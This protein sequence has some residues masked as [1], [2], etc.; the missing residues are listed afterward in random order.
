VTKSDDNEKFVRA[1][2]ALRGLRV[3][4]WAGVNTFDSLHA[5][6]VVTPSSLAS[7]TSGQITERVALEILSHEAIIREAYKDSVG[8]WT[9]SA[10]ITSAS[11]HS[12][13]RYKDNPQTLEKCLEVYIWLLREKYAPAVVGAF[14]GHKLTE[15]EF[16][17]ALSFHWNTGAIGRASWVASWK[18]GKIAQ[19]RSQFMEWRKP[20]EIIKRR[21]AECNLFFDGTWSGDGKVTEYQVAKP[22]YAPK[23]SSAKRVDVRADFKA[24]LAS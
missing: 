10:G 22:S 17:A 23:W 21:Q 8:V 11:G 4:G 6:E 13:E 9:W 18:A 5:P 12:V 15:A 7:Y 19:A 24:A 2:Q 16:C 1:Y 3:D 14:K 20:A